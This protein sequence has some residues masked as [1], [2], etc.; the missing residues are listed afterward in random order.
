M[1]QPIPEIEQPVVEELT[2]TQKFWFDHVQRSHDSGLSMAAYAR[3]HQLADKSLY[4][5][6]KRWRE[7]KAKPSTAGASL[8][9]RVRIPLSMASTLSDTLVVWLRLPNGLECELRAVT[10]SNCLDVLNALSRLPT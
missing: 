3:Q 2:E 4:H 6:V 9:H 10:V 1:Y 7:W 8:F 5:W